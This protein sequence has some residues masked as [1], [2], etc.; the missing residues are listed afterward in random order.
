METESREDQLGKSAQNK[1]L[2]PI[3]A[4]KEFYLQKIEELKSKAV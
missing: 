4:N 3:M 1:T 2:E